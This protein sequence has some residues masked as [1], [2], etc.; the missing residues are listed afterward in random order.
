MRI[1]ANSPVRSANSF[2]D[3]CNSSRESAL[4]LGQHIEAVI[5]HVTSSCMYRT[6][7]TSNNERDTLPAVSSSSI[8]KL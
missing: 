8:L 1:I 4:T 5:H 6:A 7:H 2:Y 3:E